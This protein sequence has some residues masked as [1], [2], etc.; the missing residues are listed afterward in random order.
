[1]KKTGFIILLFI[2]VSSVYSQKEAN[3]NI[4]LAVQT[5]LLQWLEKI[6]SGE[7]TNY[8]FQ[9]REEFSQASLGTPIQVFN[10][11]NDLS[12][13]S[14]KVNYLEP[15][16]EWRIP[17][18]IDQKN[19]AVVTVIKQNNDWEIVDFGAAGLAGELNDVKSHLTAEQFS[20]I[21][22][23]RLYQPLSNFLFYDDPASNPDQIILIPL[24]SA[25][26][27]LESQGLQTTKTWTLGEVVKIVRGSVSLQNQE[28]H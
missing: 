7:E 9:N 24:L 25:S 26:D 21:K 2:L 5:S 28:Q 11:G 13:Q 4:S 14:G 10:M 17:V 20:R 15:A 6:P 16:G 23:F 12:W 18:I 19:R 22:I 3:Q 1:M 27:Y 8:G